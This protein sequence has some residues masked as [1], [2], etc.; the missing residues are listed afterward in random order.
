MAEMNLSKQ[1]LYL[2]YV[3]RGEGVRVTYDEYDSF[4][5][6]ATSEAEA[7]NYHPYGDRWNDSS[8]WNMY[9]DLPSSWPV[10][11]EDVAVKL[12]GIA[13]QSL[14]AGMIIIASFNAG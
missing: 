8:L 13:D 1:P 4:V 5:V 12:I 2:W 3:S 10:K 7:R 9:D 6:V 11:P 14:D